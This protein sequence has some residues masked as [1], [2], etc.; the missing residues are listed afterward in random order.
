[1]CTKATT[2]VKLTQIRFP[3]NRP[4]TILIVQQ[5]YP[6]ITNHHFSRQRSMHPRQRC[7]CHPELAKYALFFTYV[8]PL[9]LVFDKYIRKEMRTQRRLNKRGQ[10]LRLVRSLAPLTVQRSQTQQQQLYH[11]LFISIRS[12]FPFTLSR[13]RPARA[14]SESPQRTVAKRRGKEL[15]SHYW[16]VIRVYAHTHKSSDF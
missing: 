1:M 13:S 15:N 6:V 14:R 8:T 4:G 7:H 11:V 9:Q 10:I 2:D 16:N 5:R 12:I 3:R